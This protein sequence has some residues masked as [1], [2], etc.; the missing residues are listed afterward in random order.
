[1]R[2]FDWKLTG[3]LWTDAAFLL[4]LSGWLAALNLGGPLVDPD[5]PRSATVS[6]LMLEGDWLAPRLPKVFRRDYPQDPV[7]GDFL[8]YWDKP[9]LYFWLAAL[10]MKILGPSD[11]AP[12]LPSALAFMASTLLVYAAAFRLW[13]RRAGLIAGSMAAV[14]LLALALAHVARMEA[15][16]TALMTAMLLAAMQLLDDRPGSW[17]WTLVFFGSAGLGIL[18]KG[19]IA[20]V[21]PAMAILATVALLRRWKDLRSFRPLWGILIVLLT[22]GPWF[23]YMHLRYPSGPE[24][25]GFTR[26]FFIGQ[27]LGRATTQ[28][29]GHSHFPGYL[30]TCLLG[31]CLPWTFFLPGAFSWAWGRYRKGLDPRSSLLLPVLWAVAVAGLFSLSSTQMVH[32]VLPAIPALAILA[33]GFLEAQTRGPGDRRMFRIS[34]WTTLAL[35]ACVALAFPAVLAHKGSWEPGFLPYPIL[36][37]LA[38]AAG[39]AALKKRAFS[40]AWWAACAWVLII[41]A[42]F[43]TADPTRIYLERTTRLEAGLILKSFNSDDRIAAYPQIPYSFYWYLWPLAGPHAAAQQRVA[44]AETLDELAARSKGHAK[45]F[46]LT[47]SPKTIDRLREKI[48]RP[49]TVLST[50]RKHTLAVVTGDPV[51]LGDP[52]EISPNTPR[53]RPRSSQQKAGAAAKRPP[54]LP[55]LW[56]GR[57]E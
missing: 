42:F 50:R 37:L 34:A 26:A 23:L 36:G 21:L 52:Y 18:T 54:L 15:L 48:G 55:G 16:L 17:L 49:A 22:A 35:L 53:F 24:T 8:A 7:E 32:Y 47:P 30:V 31:G 46:V 5:E 40:L 11:L 2:F 20:L 6:R 12:R 43:F 29:L 51:L 3:R 41:A 13:G 39:A 45:V 19:P 57:A 14:S 1:M 9:P 33:G 44:E 4:V 27:H 56:S 25:E 28:K 38:C 10:G